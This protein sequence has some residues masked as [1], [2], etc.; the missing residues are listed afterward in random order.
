MA[1]TVTSPMLNAERRAVDVAAVRSGAVDVLVVGGG[2][3]GA[4]VALDAASRGLSV[5][6]VE[7]NDLA[8]GTSRW[9]SKLAHGG[10]RYIAAGQI[11][12]AWESAV[13]RNHLVR[14][15]APHL[16]QPMRF[17]IPALPANSTVD[18]VVGHVGF[19]IADVLRFAARTPPVLPKTSWVD[20]SEAR[21]LAPTLRPDIKGGFLHVDGALEDDVRL[22][23]GVA[24]TAAAHGARI[25]THCTAVDVNA[26]GATVEDVLTGERFDIAARA[27]VVA[28][29]VWSGKVVSGVPLQPSKGAHLLVRP[30]ALDN[31][32]AAF[33][34]LVPGSRNRF[35]FAVPRPDG[36]V[37]IGLTDDVVDEVV[38][39]PVVTEGDEKFLLET[40]SSGLSKPVTS[41]DVVGR[42]A[43][44][45]PLLGKG[46]D[47]N[48]A[49]ISRKHAL[50]DRDGTVVIV[51][52]KL[53]TY[54]RMAE[55]A[56]NRVARRLHHH[57]TAVTTSLPLVGAVGSVDQSLP[58]RL[59]R[60]FGA[61]A[62]AVAASGPLEPIAPGIPALKC[63]VGWALSAEGAMTR[64]DV[65]GRLRLDVVPAWRNLARSYIDDV[66]SASA[67]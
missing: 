19:G 6:L 66:V 56:V 27:V 60:R 35:V 33:N 61:E 3:T 22:V 30:E 14:T 8:S 62:A 51:G 55:D 67:T 24:R 29:G 46:G 50:L 4:G 26:R 1:D 59:R 65:E 43:G 21:E 10:L 38:D 12:V 18:R 63:E 57:K 39:E 53:T 36:L 23:V 42:F 31:P 44:L 7:R 25:I 16:V 41:A 52:G 2:I 47:G 15:I 48:T 37:Q 20:P 58:A 45:R 64:G 32:V 40:L 28:A 34:I 5:A 13:E 11:G 49:D 17:V 54:R 9:S